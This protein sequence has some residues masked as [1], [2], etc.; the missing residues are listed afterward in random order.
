MIWLM[1]FP[2]FYVTFGVFVVALVAGAW[3]IGVEWREG[4]LAAEAGRTLALVW[5][6]PRRESH[7][8]GAPVQRPGLTASSDTR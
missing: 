1:M 7:R 2:L 3:L 5:D 8:E 4:R 6:R